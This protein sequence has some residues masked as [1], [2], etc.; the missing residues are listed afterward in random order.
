MK[1]I[2]EPLFLLEIRINGIQYKTIGCVLLKN[3]EKELHKL[4]KSKGFLPYK[5]LENC[6]DIVIKITKEN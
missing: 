5:N 6:D 3:A 1:W 2:K 4:F